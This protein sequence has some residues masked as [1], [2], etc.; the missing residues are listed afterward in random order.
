MDE[1]IFEILAHQ[2][3]QSLIKIV[4][5]DQTINR[6]SSKADKCRIHCSDSKYSSQN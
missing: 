4:E 1:Q 5:F 6:C 2:N 3:N